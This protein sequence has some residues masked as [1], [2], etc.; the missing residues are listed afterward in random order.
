MYKLLWVRHDKQGFIDMGEYAS[1]DEAARAIPLSRGLLVEQC[2]TDEQE[3]EIRLG[4]WE[5]TDEK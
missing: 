2:A 3:M 4:T 1:H 5:I